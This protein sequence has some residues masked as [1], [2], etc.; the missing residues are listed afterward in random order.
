[1]TH[2]HIVHRLS[3]SYCFPIVFWTSDTEAVRLRATI[4]SKNYVISFWQVFEPKQDCFKRQFSRCCFVKVKSREFFVF[5]TM[6]LCVGRCYRAT[7]AL[8]FHI[9]DLDDATIKVQVH[10]RSCRTLQSGDYLTACLKAQ[11]QRQYWKRPLSLT[12][13]LLSRFRAPKLR[14]D[15]ASGLPTRTEADGR[16]MLSKLIVV[17]IDSYSVYAI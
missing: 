8:V 5:G 4:R 16:K 6:A 11:A 9:A 14:N 12:T 10:R 2:C 7:H 13:R 1:M 15:D 17:K 3:K